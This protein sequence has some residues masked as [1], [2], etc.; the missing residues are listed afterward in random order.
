MAER[1]VVGK[2]HYG[3]EVFEGQVEIKDAHGN[4]VY[5]DAHVGTGPD[6]HKDKHP[7]GVN[8]GRKDAHGNEIW[9]TPG[10]KGKAE[11]K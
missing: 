4:R 1:R 2:D 3:N 8:T 9:H 10:A 5:R 11:D 6:H 7:G